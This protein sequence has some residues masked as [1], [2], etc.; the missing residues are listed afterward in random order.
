MPVTLDQIRTMWLLVFQG[1]EP[2]PAETTQQLCEAMW[3]KLKPHN[4]EAVLVFRVEYW[5]R[6]K[7]VQRASILPGED[8]VRRF[9]RGQFAVCKTIILPET[10]R[11]G[12]G[13]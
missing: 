9:I 2:A 7:I 1:E 8:R 6:E 13:P 12:V 5:S 11:H 3:R 10:S 4:T